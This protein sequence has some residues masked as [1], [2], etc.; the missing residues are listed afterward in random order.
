MFGKFQRNKAQNRELLQTSGA[1][2]VLAG[3]QDLNGDLVITSKATGWQ[4]RTTSNLVLNG[5]RGWWRLDEG[6][7]LVA[8]D[9]T[10]S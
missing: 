4:P 1:F 2:D 8:N 6:T 5:L 7:G 9:A 10:G 3:K